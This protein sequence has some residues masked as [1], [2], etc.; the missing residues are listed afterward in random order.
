MVAGDWFSFSSSLLPRGESS[1]PLIM[2][3]SP[4]N[5]P[6]SFSYLGAFKNSP[7]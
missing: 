1:N 7:Y 4:S 6:A 3:G 5:W 2:V